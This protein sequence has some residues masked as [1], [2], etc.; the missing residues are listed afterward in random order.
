[1]KHKK[2]NIYFNKNQIYV[3]YTN[4]N[5]LITYI[6]LNK[7]LKLNIY[8]NIMS[9]GLKRNKPNKEIGG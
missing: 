7:M 4:S 6:F 8:Y 3:N 1:M 9:I 2:Y 5:Y